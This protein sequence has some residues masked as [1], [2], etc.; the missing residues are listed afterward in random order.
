MIRRCSKDGYLNPK[1][2][3]LLV[4]RVLRQRRTSH[5]DLLPTARGSYGRRLKFPFSVYQLAHL[6]VTK[7]SNISRGAVALGA[8]SRIRDS[9]ISTLQEGFPGAFI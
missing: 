8:V 6:L 4:V 1:D 5:P 7:V 3:L 2:V 9:S